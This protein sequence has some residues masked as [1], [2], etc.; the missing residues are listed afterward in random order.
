[1]TIEISLVNK[2]ISVV[3]KRNS[4]KSI[5][6]RYLVNSQKHLFSKIFVICP[7]EKLNPFYN[8]I[9]KEDCIFDEWKEPW[10]NELIETMT[11]TNANKPENERKNVLLI[12]DDC[13]SDIDFNQ[14]AALKKIYTK[15]RH[16]NL[17]LVACLDTDKS[18]S[19]LN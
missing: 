19:I 17:G 16:F 18:L 6:I 8:K 5:L 11:K 9:T 15:G 10:A 12:L 3:A 1:M 13:M 4:G 7:T 2:T 14:S